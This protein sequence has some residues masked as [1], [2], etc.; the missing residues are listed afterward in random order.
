M[1][2]THNPHP[3]SL[4]LRSKETPKGRF[5]YSENKNLWYP[6]VTTVTGYSKKTFFNEWRK[7][8]GNEEYLL[9]A[10]DRGNVLHEAIENYINNRGFPVVSETVKQ[11]YIDVFNCMVDHLNRIDNIRLQEKPLLSDCIRIAGRVDCIGDYCG[12]PSIIDFKGSSK[13]KKAEWIQNYFEQATCYAVMYQEM[14][15]ISVKNI[16]I[17]VGCDNGTAQEFIRP[18]HP[19]IKLLAHSVKAYWRENSFEELQETLN[20]TPTT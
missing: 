10:Q 3:N 8:P 11:E 20:Q 18:I 9:R 5:Y 4:I 14:Y 16:V 19:Y 6:S 15:G 7:K 13:P 2:F 12:V 17:L 1:K